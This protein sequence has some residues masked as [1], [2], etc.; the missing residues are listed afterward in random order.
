[1]SYYFIASI[2]IHNQKEYKKYLA[3]IDEIFSRYK[4]TYLAVDSQ[5]DVI[6][7]D[8]N[9]DR[10]VRMSFDTKTNFED[11]YYLI[12]YQGILKHRLNSA[13]CTSLLVKGKNYHNNNLN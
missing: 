1:M 11:F 13:Y 6:E 8:W 4:G 9:S 3:K 2:K 10:I 5:P 7:G 12:E